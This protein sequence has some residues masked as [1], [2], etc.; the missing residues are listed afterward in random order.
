VFYD[1]KQQRAYLTDGASALFHLTCAQLNCESNISPSNRV[2]GEALVYIDPA[3]EYPA[4][5]ALQDKNNLDIVLHEE[6][7]KTTIKVIRKPDGQSERQEETE[8]RVWKV[9][10]LVK[11]NWAVL[12][13][14]WELHASEKSG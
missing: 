2:A 12:S 5:V 10:D 1:T 8:I 14:L 3:A 4:V 6:E 7:T 13:K 11:D 9:Q